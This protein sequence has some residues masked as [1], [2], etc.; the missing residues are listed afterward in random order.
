MDDVEHRV[1]E[2]IQQLTI[3]EKFQLLSSP[4]LRRL[5]STKGI[6]RLGIPEYRMTDGPL[7]VA[8]QSS[9]KHA[10]RFPV[11]IA[12]AATW[13][14]SLAREMGKAVGREV[15]SAGRHMLLA[16]GI[17]IAR[18]PLKGRTFEY[19]SEDPLLTRELAAEV[20]E[21]V[22]SEGVGACLKHFAANN[23]DTDRRKSSSEIDERTLHE[24]YLRAFRGVVTRSQPFSIMAAYN[25][26]NGVYCSENE[27]LLNDVLMERWG[28]E[29]FVM[30]DWFS[31]YDSDTPAQSINAGFSL[32]MPRPSRYKKSKLMKAFNAGEFDE[33][34]LNDLVSRLLR[35]MLK[36]GAFEAAKKSSKNIS[37]EEHRHLAR[38]I[39]QDSIVL[40]KNEGEVLPLHR[41]ERVCVRGPNLKKRYGKFLHGGSSAVIPPYEVTPLEAMKEKSTKLIIDDRLSCALKSDAVVLFVGLDHKKGNDAEF[42][43]RKTLALP[44]K[45]VKLIKEFARGK[46]K[47][48]VVLMAGS[49]ISMDDWIDGVDAV[50]LTWYP[51]MTGSHAIADML[52]GEVN[53]CGKLPITFPRRIEDSPAHSTGL[54]KNY[55]GDEESRVFYDEGIFVGYRWFDNRDVDPLFPFGYGLSYTEFRLDNARVADDNPLLVEVDITNIGD[56]E[57]A[58]VVQIYAHDVEASV[59]RPPKELVGFEK[60]Y[61]KP[62]ETKTVR[63]LIDAMDLGFYDANQHDW[64]LEPGEFTLMIGT[65][66]R[67]LPISIPIK[68]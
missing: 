3:K 36:T 27:Y 68:L 38:R 8:Y 56:H 19:F 51:G 1:Q 13:N 42:G 53:P 64:L 7:G 24:T 21:G 31:S 47:K 49:P 52:Y 25:R 59:E 40:L 5:Y 43:D 26:L 6:K 65:S 22:Q 16:P 30:T 28:F 57:G 33:E 35:V 9:R 15:R 55:P 18:T 63:I 32:E 44:E 46:M 60:V 34:R 17:N 54:E 50:V 29:G 14:R 61:L 48:I 41:D 20:V 58:E 2:L 45:Q 67:H 66:S 62:R 37:Q 39:A 10:T 4:G 11:T 23:Q 12:V